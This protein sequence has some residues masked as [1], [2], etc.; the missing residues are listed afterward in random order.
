MSSML[1]NQLRFARSEFVRGLVG[2]S[3]EEARRRFGAMNSISWMIGHM[4]DQENRYWVWWGQGKA[5]LPELRNQVGF[6]RPAS[7]PPLEEMWSAWRSATAA[8]DLF[9]ETLNQETLTSHFEQRG[10]PIAEN[11]GT[12]LL[13]NIYHYWYHTGEAHAVRQMLGHTDLPQFIGRITP[14]QP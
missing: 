7:T 3:D 6:G 10:Q 11:V 4:A 1:V 13:R 8:A 2:V 5:M 9:L 12:L 14:Y